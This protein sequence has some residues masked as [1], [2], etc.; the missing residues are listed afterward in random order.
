M[1]FRRLRLL[2]LAALAPALLLP[3]ACKK[4]YEPRAIEW[5]IEPAAGKPLRIE[6]KLRRNL[7]IHSA[8]YQGSYPEV[9]TYGVQSS[10]EAAVD[11]LSS[12]AWR[13]AADYA[14]LYIAD[15]QP[16]ELA[17]SVGGVVQMLNHKAPVAID[18]KDILNIMIRNAKG[19]LRLKDGSNLTVSSLE[20]DLVLD[21]V[22]VKIGGGR[23]EASNIEGSLHASNLVADLSVSHLSGDLIGRELGG[24]VELSSLDGMTSVSCATDLRLCFFGTGQVNGKPRLE[25]EKIL[26]AQGKDISI[27]AGGRV[28][29]ESGG[30]R[31]IRVAAPALALNG[32]TALQTDLQGS[33]EC[34]LS[35]FNSPLRMTR[36]HRG[37]LRLA[38][39]YELMQCTGLMLETVNP[40]HLPG[41][42]RRH[43]RDCSEIVFWRTPPTSVTQE[44]CQAVIFPK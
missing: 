8:L 33:R 23:V 41:S 35:Y 20:G 6:A 13:V 39:D 14:E 42:R 3:L 44:N 37:V 7:T 5:R 32:I 26:A 9:I 38:G 31:N 17:G 25:A 27:R 24:R 11:R 18:G 2:F 4:R 12:G 29:L 22:G 19:G 16:L 15:D 43:L 28:E 10:G 30:V 36:C 34:F 1:P 21:D 40:E